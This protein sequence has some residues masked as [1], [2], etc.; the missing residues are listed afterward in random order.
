MGLDALAHSAH[1]KVTAQGFMLWSQAAYCN[2]ASD[3]E[4]EEALGIQHALEA[5]GLGYS[6]PL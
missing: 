5:A 4:R 6:E 2:E 1:P 3:K